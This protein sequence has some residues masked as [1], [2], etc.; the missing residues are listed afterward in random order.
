M[1]LEEEVAEDIQ[2]L[3]TLVRGHIGIHGRNGTFN[4]VLTKREKEEAGKRLGSLLH[5]VADGAF[6]PLMHFTLDKNQ[7]QILANQKEISASLLV[8]HLGIE[9]GENFLSLSKGEKDKV[10]GQLKSL[11]RKFANDAL[12]QLMDCTLSHEEVQEL[13]SLKVL[14]A[15]ETDTQR[16]GLEDDIGTADNTSD[17]IDDT[18][19]WREEQGL[20]VSAEN[21]DEEEE[22]EEESDPNPASLES[23]SSEEEILNMTND[24]LESDGQSSQGNADKEGKEGCEKRCEQCNKEFT[25]SSSLKIHLMTHSGERPFKC[26]VCSKTFNRLY[27]LQSHHLTHT[28][29]QMK[30]RFNYGGIAIFKAVSTL[31]KQL[32]TILFTI[33]HFF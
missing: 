7:V 3:Q 10:G 30:N 26:P 13:W 16:E 27:H 6:L 23:L 24:N 8:E 11:L 25:R 15:Y 28:G 17:A 12:I 29:K 20:E 31:Q 19:V 2:T 5:V 14:Q 9:D 18:P 21:D 32:L 4:D 1:D 33:V 22:D